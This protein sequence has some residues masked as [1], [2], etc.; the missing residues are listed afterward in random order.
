MGRGLRLWLRPRG[1]SSADGAPT[2]PGAA[3]GTRGP[4]HRRASRVRGFGEPSLVRGF[5][6]V[7]RTT[8]LVVV[9]PVV[10]PRQRGLSPLVPKGTV[11]STVLLGLFLD[12]H[13]G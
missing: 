3:R 5:G 13:R 8:H 6:V 9:R 7:R 1:P 12:T 11:P 2:P 10:G 4:K